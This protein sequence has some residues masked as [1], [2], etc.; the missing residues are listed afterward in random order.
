[1]K[2]RNGE[3]G[4][5]TGALGIVLAALALCPVA[6]EAQTSLS[7][8]SDGRVV[9]R[10]TLPE[11]LQKGA[12][13]LT[14]RIEGLDPATLFCPDTAVA[15][16]GAIVRPPSSPADALAGAAG[17][18]L[19]F[20]RG[21]GDTI[22]ATVIRVDPPQ[23]RLADGRLLLS[24][25]G[26]PVFPAELVRTAPEVALT[27]VASRA[28][29]AT[30]LAY[31]AQGV[32]WE[33]TYQAILSPDGSRGSIGGAATVTSQGVRADSAQVQLVAGS[34]KR[35]RPA[36]EAGFVA[37][38]VAALAVSAEAAPAEQAV[39]E[40]HV[41]SLPGRLSLAPGVPVTV[42]LFPR[43]MADVTQE[44]VVPGVL[45]WRGY[46]SQTP[47]A[48][49]QVPVQVWY[50]FARGRGSA[51]GDRPLPAGTIQLYQ[52]DSSD[53]LQL[54]GEAAIGHTPA[55]KDVRVQSGDAFDVTAERVQTDYS[56]EHI[57]SAQRGLPAHTRVTASYRVTVT[58]AKPTVIT[59]DVRETHLGAWRVVESSVPAEQL[60]STESRFRLSVPAGGTAVLT[61]T[62]QVDS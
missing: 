54:I 49:N 55:G 51:F 52:P 18:T 38:R 14:L 24:S 42:A 33:A 39:G 44:F 53:R 11:A 47:A 25:P 22:R 56:Q 17:R 34:V 4:T 48:P 26:E 7:I 62:V 21:K 61:Y 3:C 46:V 5:R 28:R 27:L 10:R 13:H 23:Y 31:I 50:S 58:N 45:P 60:S 59:A 16:T 29:P 57:A 32:K 36:P 30:Q 9:V 6:L 1:M 35:V 41:Y 20:V 19:N 12:N 15:V 40:T 8:Y 37:Q 43:A 2:R